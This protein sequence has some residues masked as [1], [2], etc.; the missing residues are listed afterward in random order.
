MENLGWTMMTYGDLPEVAYGDLPEVQAYLAEHERKREA[1]DVEI[2]RVAALHWDWRF[3]H[4]RYV[5][6]PGIVK[7]QAY[8]G[9]RAFTGRGAK[10]AARRR[11]RNLRAVSPWKAS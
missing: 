7:W 9:G 3:Y 2:R 1:A 10:R 4:G 6:R 11:L 5:S 8:E